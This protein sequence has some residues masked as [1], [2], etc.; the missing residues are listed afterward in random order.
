VWVGIKGIGESGAGE[1]VAGFR[2]HRLAVLR[3]DDPQAL[4][5]LF[6]EIADGKRG[7]HGAMIAMMALL[8]ILDFRETP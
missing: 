3:C 6:V 5:Y 4:L 8:S 2:F 1:D 7:A